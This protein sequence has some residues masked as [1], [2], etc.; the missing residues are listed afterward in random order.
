MKFQQVIWLAATKAGR[1]PDEACGA[2]NAMREDFIRQ[3]GEDAWIKLFKKDV[4]EPTALQMIAEMG[5]EEFLKKADAFANSKEQRK[6]QASISE[7]IVLRRAGVNSVADLVHGPINAKEYKMRLGQAFWPYSY[8]KTKDDLGATEALAKELTERSKRGVKDDFYLFCTEGG[9]REFM[10]SA[11]WADQGFPVVRLCGHKYAAALLSSTLSADVVFEAPWKSFLIEVPKGLLVVHDD[12]Q[13]PSDIEWVHVFRHLMFRAPDWIMGWSYQGVSNRGVTLHRTM[14]TSGDL[15]SEE[16]QDF[17]E[18]AF[19]L[20][21]D[22]R[23]ARLQALLSRLVVNVCVA[24]SDPRN[25]Q[26]VGKNHDRESGSSQRTTMDPPFR[27]FVVGKPV[28]VDCRQ[29]LK[30]Y[31]DGERGA[32]IA[33]QFL[34]RGHFRNQACGPGHTERRVLWIEPYWKGPADAPINMRPHDLGGQ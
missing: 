10:M 29:A 33:V 22:S 16:S 7:H 6:M 34:V 25:V 30:D 12:K 28:Q 31:I 13:Q 24:M 17:L 14:L 21:A 9:Q 3:F 2:I 19:S 15:K 5:S 4:D 11:R 1:T 20:K 23:D 26:R 32:P 18:D 27:V 8:A